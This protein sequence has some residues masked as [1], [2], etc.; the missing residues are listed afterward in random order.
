MIEHLI[1]YD[2]MMK[3][4][5]QIESIFS[6]FMHVDQLQGF[7]FIYQCHVSSRVWTMFYVQLLDKI[8]L[9]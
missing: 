8:K 9:Y 2:S 6:H 4:E 7:D 3:T 5:D 1:Q